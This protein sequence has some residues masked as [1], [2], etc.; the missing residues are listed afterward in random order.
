MFIINKSYPFYLLIILSGSFNIR[1]LGTETPYFILLLAISYSFFILLFSKKSN[2]NKLEKISEV[3]KK[4]NR[5]P[6]LTAYFKYCWISLIFVWSY[7]VLVGL[8]NSN[9]I[10]HV[11]RNFFGL[12]FY[13]AVF[14]LVYL[15]PKFTEMVNVIFFIFIIQL[16]IGTH[17]SFGK[18]ISL[19]DF[20]N[21]NSMSDFRSGYSG[22]FTV[23][24]IFL[25]VSLFYLTYKKEYLDRYNFKYL[26]SNF[27]ALLLFLFS[28]FLIII[29]SFSK[30]FILSFSIYTLFFFIIIIFSI[31][32]NLK[33]HTKSFIYLC[34]FIVISFCLFHFLGDVLI[35][36]FSSEEE[37]NS[38]R[39]VQFGFLINELT[40]FG[41]G[42]GASLKSGF[43]SG[44]SG[45]YGFE[46]TYI[47]L[48]HKFGVLSIIIFYSYL[49]II[50]YAILNIIKK[51]YLM[52]SFFCLGLMGFLVPG[53]GN[54]ILISPIT[55]LFH[56]IALYISYRLTISEQK[57]NSI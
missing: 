27:K 52:E 24:F 55:V 54:P 28:S 57:N 6:W 48:I 43:N 56:S 35:Y 16:I 23:G 21:I 45:G 25:S 44:G 12:V 11:F 37:S 14:S 38:A 47:S 15:K 10:E 1:E 17:M 2:V 46:L 19:W 13:I 32:F 9:P 5:T 4:L 8:L 3:D 50:G 18:I 31:F 26:N 30:G 39:N 40:F 29:P 49:S 41:S 34:S 22:A 33:I 51:K 36:S 7:G 20:N 42:L 53:A